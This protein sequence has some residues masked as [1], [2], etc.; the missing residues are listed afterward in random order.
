MYHWHK[1]LDV[2]KFLTA[3]ILIIGDEA[4]REQISI[5]LKSCALSSKDQ[6][7]NLGVIFDS[8]LNFKAHISNVT[9]IS[10]Y[11]LRN[12]VRVR[13][14]LSQTDT[15]RIMHAFI[16]SRIDY[17]NAL[18]SGVSKTEVARLQLVQNAAARVLT[19]TKRRAH[20]TPILKSLHWLPVT[21]RIDFKVILLVFKS[22]NRNA[23]AY[24]SAMLSWYE[25]SRPL[26]SSNLGLLNVPEV[27]TRRQGEAA[28]S[29][30]GPTLWNSLPV[31][32][33]LS[34]SDSID[35]FKRNLKTHLF[36]I[37]FN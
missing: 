30:Y 17:C 34:V 31:N 28:F 20:I 35:N 3:E 14:F 37:A 7:K 22:L 36:S 4:T 15:E 16:T 2:W 19:K 8:N 1:F 25:P 24:L 10:F 21:L 29:F 26:R 27:E 9:K 5:K 13:G 33:R 12:I 32:L 11:H 23:P 18:L 6:V